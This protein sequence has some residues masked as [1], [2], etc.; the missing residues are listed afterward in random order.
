MEDV[1]ECV[2]AHAFVRV[3]VFLCMCVQVC[4][5]VCVCVCVYVCICVCVIVF[6]VCVL[7]H[8]FGVVCFTSR[9]KKHIAIV[10]LS[11]STPVS[12]TSVWV[13]LGELV[14]PNTAARDPRAI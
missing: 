6:I 13:V 9:F 8:M 14:A 7:V 12:N 2:C 5:C 1:C 10:Y 4:V 3:R 11:G